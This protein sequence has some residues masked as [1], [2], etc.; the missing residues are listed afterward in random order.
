VVSLGRQLYS[1]F[2]VEGPRPT[3]STCHD[4]EKSAPTAP[5][6]SVGH[7]KKKLSR[8]TL[9]PG[10]SRRNDAVL[11]RARRDRGAATPLRRSTR[12]NGA[13]GEARIVE[14]LKSIP[15]TSMLKKAFPTRRSR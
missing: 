8:N 13:A 10:R 5:T 9:H 4:L 3:C 7:G 2:V 1:T 12:R 14:T 6:S 15:L 11:G